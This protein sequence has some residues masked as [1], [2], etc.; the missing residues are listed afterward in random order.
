ML[1]ILLL[2]SIFPVLAVPVQDTEM[3]QINQG[4]FNRI[5]YHFNLQETDSIY[6][7]SSSSFK[8]ALSLEALES[9]LTQQLYPLGQI[10]SAEMLS[11]DRSTAT[12]IYRID[13]QTTTLQV[14]LSNTANRQ[15]TSLVFQPFEP[16][17]KANS[18]PV[19]T[20]TK[21]TLDEFVD[22]LAFSYTRNP[23][24][25]ALA[26]GVLDAGKR[27]EYFYGGVA[28]GDNKLPNEQSLFELGSITK[29][30]AATLLA[31]MDE[32]GMLSIHDRIV[33]YLPDSVRNNPHLASITFQQLA[34]H[35]SGLPRL[36]DNLLNAPAHHPQNPYMG[37]TAGDLFTYLQHYRAQNEPGEEYLYS[38]LGYAVLGTILSEVTGQ[39]MAEM[40]QQIIA[41]PLRLSNL[42]QNSTDSSDF[43]PVHNQQGAKVPAWDFDAF[44][45]AGALKSTVSDLLTY[46]AAHFER[47]ESPLENALAKTRQ[48]TFFNPPDTDVGLGWHMHLHGADLLFWHN[49]ETGGSNSYIAFSPDRRIAVV[50]LA[51]T[52][53]SV[54]E[55]AQKIQEFL[56]NK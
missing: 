7:L 20:S 37:Y 53:V 48:F 49:G 14:V 22:S 8:T 2:S 12:G 30:F 11:F 21:K 40:V 15:Y 42:L 6:A 39:S 10:Q 24:A 36:P 5:E 56:L 25:H 31:Y 18:L 29:T 43:L 13:F 46:A 34:N 27:I 47:P 1:F 38:N 54:Q 45:A 23:G 50:A 55:L 26:V 33:N 41:E 19:I 44:A 16:P 28:A 17:T 51:N 52:T 32:T 9:V 35:T 3:K 4:I